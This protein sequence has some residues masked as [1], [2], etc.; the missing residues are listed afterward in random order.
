MLVDY[1]G[2][3][4]WVARRAKARG[5]PVFY[6]V[7]PQIW[8][9]AGWRIKKVKKYVDVVLCSLPF[10]PAWYRARGFENAF[11]V[12]HPYFDEL[13]DRPLDADFLADQRAKR[14]TDFDLAWIANPGGRA[15]PS[16]DD[17]GGEQ[18]GVSATRS[19]IRSGLPARPT[20]EPG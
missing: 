10:E 16:G 4:W 20:P 9:W 13:K 17:P 19:S 12:G 7:P 6:F 5:I 3:H 2:F 15:K 1:P 8:A 11:H 18:A 14:R